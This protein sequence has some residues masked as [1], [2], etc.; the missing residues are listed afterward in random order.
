MKF[1]RTLFDKQ[2]PLFEKGGKLEVFYPLFEAIESFHFTPGKVTDGAP[3]V[4]DAVDL[5]RIMITVVVSLMPAIFLGLWNIGYQ[6]NSGLAPGVTPEGWRAGLV[7]AL[8]LGFSPASFLACFVHGALYFLP[9]LIVTFMVGGSIEVAVAIIR[10][11]DVNE[12][13]FVTGFLIPLILP[14]TIPLW[15][16][17]LATA[18]GVVIGKEVFGGTG[19]NIFN[20]ALVT[21]AF[22]YFAYPIQSSGD[23]VWV[24]L[25]PAQAAD[26]FSGATLLARVA[27]I[28]PVADGQA[29]QTA[30]STMQ[31]NG[32]AVSWLDAFIGW[33]PGSM[34]ET[35]T[36]ACLVGAAILLITGVASWRI[37]VSMVAGALGLVLL[38][39]AAG[40]QTNE[41]M[42]LPFHWHFVL[43]GF[44]FG[45]VFMAT[46]PV[47]GTYTETG[48]Y[49]YGFG[50]G[51]M[52]ILIRALNPAYPE[53]VMLA[54][55]F[56]NILAPLIDYA[57]V[58]Q[59]IKRR[60]ARSA[61]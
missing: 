24:A 44:A 10:K 48:K 4:R 32:K 5:K 52:A 29:W 31:I 1:I 45:L 19:M 53:G 36:L 33:I 13:F 23:K 42:N 40:S 20:P 61:I 26:G 38:M 37:M 51:V 56:M 27:E 9:V 21:R 46:E 35:S 34:G 57:V 28:P 7:A 60:A 11:H 47:T 41:L 55:L 17:A 50:I 8:G 39:N 16:V 30:V 54:I 2:A 49:I 59:N 22:L 25:N 6:I 18:F 3:H 43:G 12:G 15:Q 58:S 14:P